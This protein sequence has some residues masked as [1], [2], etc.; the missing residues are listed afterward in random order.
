MTLLAVCA[1]AFILGLIMC[2]LVMFDGP[3]W[4]EPK[5]LYYPMS[6]VGPTLVF[7]SSIIFLIFGN[8]C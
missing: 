3:L 6:I 7:G 2:L 1:T 4:K 8:N 5:G